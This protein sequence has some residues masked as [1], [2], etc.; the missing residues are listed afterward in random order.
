MRVLFAYPVRLL[1]LHEQLVCTHSC[2]L[3]YQTLS[4]LGVA[5]G[6]LLRPIIA[7]A[8]MSRQCRLQLN[9]CCCYADQRLSC[10]VLHF[11]AHCCSR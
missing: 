7:G 3:Q 2:Y 6:V 5:D 9:V 8:A 11:I 4:D 10:K 1:E